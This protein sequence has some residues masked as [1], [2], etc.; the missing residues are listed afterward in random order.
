MGGEHNLSHVCGDNIYMMIEVAKERARG[1]YLIILDSV[2]HKKRMSL[3][4][5]YSKFKISCADVCKKSRISR[6]TLKASSTTVRTGVIQVRYSVINGCSLC[7][8]GASQIISAMQTRTC[9]SDTQ[10][11]PS[12]AGYSSCCISP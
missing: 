3:A 1:Q 6:N 10:V 8:A 4:L 11:K 9:R 7:S 12:Q 2:L 5:S